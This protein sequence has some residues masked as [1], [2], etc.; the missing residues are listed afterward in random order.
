MR[1]IR[2]RAP[3]G[4]HHVR[5]RQQ[6]Y[7]HPDHVRVHEISGPRSTPPATRNASR[8]GRAV[9]ALKILHR[10]VGPADPRPQRRSSREERARTPSGSSAGFRRRDRRTLHHVHRRE[11]FPAQ[12]PRGPARAPHAG[13][14]DRVLDAF[15][16]RGRT[17]RS[18]RGREFVLARSLVD[19][20]LPTEMWRTTSS[21]ACA[22][23]S[24]PDRT[25]SNEGCHVE[26]PEPGMD[27]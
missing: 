2:S 19:T 6:F 26:V 24:A 17:R 4:D 18:S 20:E 16:G 7:P 10:V 15:A 8:L 3:A 9:A 27:R 22:H 12:A 21:P 25:S 13:R 5:G 23:P 14:S 11:R 1:I